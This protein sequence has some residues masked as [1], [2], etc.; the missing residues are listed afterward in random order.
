[1]KPGKRPDNLAKKNNRRMNSGGG[2]GGGD[3]FGFPRQWDTRFSTQL[4]RCILSHDIRHI[5]NWH[6]PSYSLF[7]YLSIVV[8]LIG[9]SNFRSTLHYMC[10]LVIGAICIFGAAKFTQ[11]ES[12]PNAVVS[13]GE[14]KVRT[15]SVVEFNV[16]SMYARWGAPTAEFL[17]E[18]LFSATKLKDLRVVGGVLIALLLIGELAKYVSGSVIFGVIVSLVFFVGGVKR[19][20]TM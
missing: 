1:M 5:L 3:P 10:A 13:P 17:A 8:T 2:G 4:Q 16:K 15:K 12:G 14:L 7:V 6:T 19:L 20:T 18:N 9:I 11:V